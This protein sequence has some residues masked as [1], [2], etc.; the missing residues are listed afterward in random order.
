LPLDAFQ[1]SKANGK[2]T[3]DCAAAVIA[4]NDKGTMI[5]HRA[6]QIAFTL[7]DD[8]AAHP[9]GKFL[10]ADLEI[11]LSQGDVYLYLAAWDMASKRLGTLEIPYHV[12]S[13]KKAKDMPASR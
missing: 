1:I 12:E 10:P 6:Q 3:V 5:A 7:R 11:N 9:A 4:F 13:P 2:S 8:A